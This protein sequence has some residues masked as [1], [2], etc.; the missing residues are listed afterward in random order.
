MNLIMNKLPIIGAKK[1]WKDKG[2]SPKQQTLLR[3]IISPPCF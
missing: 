1:H 2:Q 3:T